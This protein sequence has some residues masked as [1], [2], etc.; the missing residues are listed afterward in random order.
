MAMDAAL[1]ETMG[2]VVAYSFA[3]SSMTLLN[4]AA[5]TAF[6]FPYFLCVLQNLATLFFLAIVVSIAPKDHKIFGLRAGS[7]FSLKIFKQWS[8]AVLLF[9]LMLVSSM[10]AMRSMSVTKVTHSGPT[11]FTVAQP[12]AIQ[13]LNALGLGL[14]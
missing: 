9:C 12:R 14:A 4:K 6:T 1:Y 10:S 5:I 11:L 8:P 13:R 3:S 7:G 2:W